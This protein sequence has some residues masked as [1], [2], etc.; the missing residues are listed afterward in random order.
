MIEEQYQDPT[1]SVAG[2]VKRNARQLE[3]TPLISSIWK[4]IASWL[5]F[6][7]ASWAFIVL[8]TLLGLW[9]A[10]ETYFGVSLR[11]WLTFGIVL[12]ILAG[13]SILFWLA[14]KRIRSG[15][16]QRE[17]VHLEQGF[18]SLGKAYQLAVYGVVFGVTVYLLAAIWM[19]TYV[20]LAD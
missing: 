14:S 1:E 19:Y 18:Q 4:E 7:S 13:V 2:S 12:S 9:Y 10:S 20:A 8:V 15:L 11:M 5:L 16:E 6:W 3:I 17:S